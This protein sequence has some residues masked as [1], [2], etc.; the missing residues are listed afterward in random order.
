MGLA[1]YTQA[2]VSSIVT[3]ESS[4]GKRDGKKGR[5]KTEGREMHWKRRRKRSLRAEPAEEEE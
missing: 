1:A 3:Q 2:L 5:G 4:G